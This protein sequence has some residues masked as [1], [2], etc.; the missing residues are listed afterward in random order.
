MKNPSTILE[1]TPATGT[2]CNKFLENVVCT[3]QGRIE[4]YL[5]RVRLGRGSNECL[6]ASKQ[7]G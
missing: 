3:E 6:Q 7:Q 5:S 2:T 1:M 4:G